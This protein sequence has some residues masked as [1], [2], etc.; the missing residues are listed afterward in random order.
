MSKPSMS[1]ALSASMSAE[2]D[3]FQERLARAEARFGGA[4]N[5][6]GAAATE[7]AVVAS[8]EVEAPAETLPVPRVM[9]EAFTIPEAEHFQ[10]EAIRAAMLTGAVAVSKSEVI[11]AGLLLLNECDE[12][13]R[14]AVFERLERVK[15]GRPKMV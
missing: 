9:R 11:R 14:R 13:A 2:T 1:D 4:A 3:A 8:A 12:T 5:D 15:T 7:A 6:S 10:I